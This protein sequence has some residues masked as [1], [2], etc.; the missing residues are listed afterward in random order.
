MA[1]ESPARPPLAL[2]GAFLQRLEYL[3]VVARKILAGVLRADRKSARKGVSAEFADHRAYVPGDDIRHV[4]WHLFGR[5]EELFLKLYREEENLHLCLLVDTSASMDFGERHKLDFALQ[6]TAALAYIGMCNLDSVSVLPFGS[7]LREGRTGLKGR[8]RIFGLF[9][10]LREL[11]PEGETD[12][13]RSLREFVSRQGRRGVVVV[14]SDFYD[15]EGFQS[16]LKSLRIRKHDVHVLHVMDRLEEEPP[17]RG[18]LRLQDSESGGA[19]EI[20]VTDRLLERYRQAFEE[21]AGRVE[22]FCIRNQMG[23]VRARTRIPFDELVLGIL[24]RGGVVG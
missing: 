17:L 18:D 6:V 21:Q 14:L 7:G 5:L 8:G 22:A 10:F 11:R 20:N 13:Q 9:D 15:Q 16:A 2:D 1:A 23:Y 3:N 24:R 19:R 4:D 12:L